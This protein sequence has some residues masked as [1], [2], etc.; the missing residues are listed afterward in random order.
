MPCPHFSVQDNGC[1][2]AM[3]AAVGDEEER[4]PIE[5]EDPADLA[6]CLA[7]DRRYR[8]CRTYCNLVV[9]LSP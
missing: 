9:E 1:L 5:I 4:E 2:L 3:G 7:P 8:T 6:L